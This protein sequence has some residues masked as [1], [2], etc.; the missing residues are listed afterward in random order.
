[1]LEARDF[2]DQ[3]IW[4]EPRCGHSSV[5]FD[6]WSK[7]DYLLPVNYPINFEVEDLKLL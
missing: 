5:W 1:M 4:W 6:N 3:D 7:L 2:I